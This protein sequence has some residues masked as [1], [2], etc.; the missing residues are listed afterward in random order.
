MDLK[1]KQRIAFIRPRNWPLANRIVEDV[2][3]EQFPDYSVDV[4]DISKMIRTRPDI[5]LRNSLETLALY[6]SE[7]AR[8]SKKFRLAFW[9]TP[10][11]FQQIRELVESQISSA[12]YYFSF[13]MQS[14][15]DASRKGLPHF[16][17]TDHTHLENLHYTANG[18][19][20]LYSE[21]WIALERTIYHNASLNFV[22]SSNVRRSMLLDYECAADKVELVY[23]GRNA[24]VTSQKT[25]NVDYSRPHILFVGYDWKRKGGPDLVEA[26]QLVLES[27][28]N[29]RLTIVGAQPDLNIPNCE[30]I[31]PGRAADLDGYYQRASVFCMPTYREPF[32]IAFIEAMA[33]RLPIV[34]TRVGAIPDFVEE[35]RNGWLLEP[36]D[37][38]GIADALMSL[39]QNP[40]MAGEFGENSYR[41][42]QQ[43]Y[44]WD[45]VGKRLQECICGALDGSR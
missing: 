13:Q 34:A 38:Q 6:G 1:R 26:F 16:V 9:R 30:V 45:T 11:I 3:Q 12:D 14:L 7:I 28:P 42:V 22:R 32:G 35:G 8:R 2:I 27:F 24:T 20:T 23:A 44:T 19:D 17:Y 4:F 21:G 25:E 29:A 39:L 33:A 37:I 15:F 10:Y 18:K 43:R 31:G 40:G 5:I 36:G 41:I